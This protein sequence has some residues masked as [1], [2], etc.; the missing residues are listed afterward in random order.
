MVLISVGLL[1]NSV[2]TALFTVII[3][4]MVLFLIVFTAIELFIHKET[5]KKVQARDNFWQWCISDIVIQW[6]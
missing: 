4:L 6:F 5:I 1:F 2:I 3:F